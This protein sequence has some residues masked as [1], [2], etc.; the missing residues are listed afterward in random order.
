L[1]DDGSILS[2]NLLLQDVTAPLGI[3]VPGKEKSQH[4]GANCRYLW[5]RK[6]V[7]L[8]TSQNIRKVNMTSVCS[9]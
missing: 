1:A 8:T 7:I 5:I 2:S 9:V 4:S 6:Q 3:N